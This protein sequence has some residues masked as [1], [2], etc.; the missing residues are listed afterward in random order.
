MSPCHARAGQAGRLAGRRLRKRSALLV[1]C[2]AAVGQAPSNSKPIRSGALPAQGH[3]PVLAVDDTSVRLARSHVHTGG[4]ERLP[5]ARRLARLDR[6]GRLWT[7]IIAW[8]ETWYIA[9]HETPTTPVV[10]AVFPIFT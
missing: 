8:S 6:H 5:Q 2:V 4:T 3:R 9:D 10:V 7:G 1:S